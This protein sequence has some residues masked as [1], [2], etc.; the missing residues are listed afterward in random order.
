MNELGSNLPVTSGSSKRKWQSGNTIIKYESIMLHLSQN[1]TNELKKMNGQRCIFEIIVSIHFMSLGSS[2]SYLSC[3]TKLKSC[4]S[5][6][7]I[8]GDIDN[9]VVLYYC[10]WVYIY[11]VDIQVYKAFMLGK[12]MYILE[13]FSYATISGRHTQY[14]STSNQSLRRVYRDCG[15]ALLYVMAYV[16]KIV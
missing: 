3:L 12:Q 5:R 14:I 2:P 9:T 6:L 4:E 13:H 11:L 16:I 10:R 7:Y 8:T 1:A 15:L